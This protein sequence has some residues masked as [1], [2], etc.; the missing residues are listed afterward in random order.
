V[1]RE[2]YRFIEPVSDFDPFVAYDKKYSDEISDLPF[3][4]IDTPKNTI[5]ISWK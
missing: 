4:I 2:T 3:T 1:Q 5:H